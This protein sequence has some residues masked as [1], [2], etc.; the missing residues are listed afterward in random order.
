MAK[1]AIVIAGAPGQ[2]WQYVIAN[3]RV[4]RDP[5]RA[6]Y[7]IESWPP[8]QNRQQED[9][10]P[11]PD[12]SRDW[13]VGEILA[14]VRVADR[15]LDEDAP[16]IYR[17]NPLA[18]R[19]RRIAAGPASEGQE[20][21]D[22]LNLATGGNPRKGVIGDDETIMGELGDTAVAALLAIQ[23]ITKDTDVTWA[24]FLAALSKILARVPEKYRP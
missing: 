24:M 10:A 4:T 13:D 6:V 2:G 3:H 18:N 22:A 23:S 19:W 8:A 20:S 15:W 12:L 21:V 11:W 16:E 14:A 5:D 7:W 1:H 17:T 9:P